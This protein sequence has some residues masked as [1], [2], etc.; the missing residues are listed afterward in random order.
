MQGA[1]SDDGREGMLRRAKSLS[2]VVVCEWA[3]RRAGR[4]FGNA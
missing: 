4:V 1:G 3:C 2:K